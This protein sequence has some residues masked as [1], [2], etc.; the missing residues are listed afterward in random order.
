M[1]WLADQFGFMFSA[2]V[3]DR[4]EEIAILS[5]RCDAQAKTIEE[6]LQSIN[7][8]ASTVTSQLE[9]IRKLRLDMQLIKNAVEHSESLDAQ[10]T[11]GSSICQSE[12]E[13]QRIGPLDS[14]SL[15]EFHPK[16]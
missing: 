4:A 8:L 2:G 10:F 12:E 7:A 6:Q 3:S 16:S 1:S 9:I 15:M 5:E 13:E 11:E 14:L